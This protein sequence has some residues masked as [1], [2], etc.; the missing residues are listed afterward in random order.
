MSI[1][2]AKAMVSEAQPLL[3]TDGSSSSAE[4]VASG[5][6]GKESFDKHIA[7]ILQRSTTNP[8]MKASANMTSEESY[9]I[10]ARCTKGKIQGRESWV[11]ICVPNVRQ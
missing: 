5:H 10:L 3:C 2:L 1:S 4:I 7:L 9:E 8:L 11:R 6:Q